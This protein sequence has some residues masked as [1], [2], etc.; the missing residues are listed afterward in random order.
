MARQPNDTTAKGMWDVTRPNQMRNAQY[1]N[2]WPMM[3]PD[4]ATGYASRTNYLTSGDANP[5]S[6]GINNWGGFYVN[7]NY[8]HA[9]S[10][11]CT[12]HDWELT[13]WGSGNSTNQQGLVFYAF[14]LWE[15]QYINDASKVIAPYTN[16]SGALWIPNNGIPAQQTMTY[17]SSWDVPAARLTQNQWY[18]MGQA[19]TQASSAAYHGYPAF[20]QNGGGYGNSITTVSFTCSATNAGGTN[21]ETPT[22]E[23]ADPLGQTASTAPFTSNMGL[24]SIYNGSFI[25]SGIRVF[26]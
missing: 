23:W 24:T 3:P 18:T 8:F 9:L 4:F 14:Q 5:A 22:F 6:T 1:G 21:Y 11:R 19:Y 13:Y 15:G 25:T 16:L 17:I 7:Q 2:R 20:Y 10:I 26:S 12:T